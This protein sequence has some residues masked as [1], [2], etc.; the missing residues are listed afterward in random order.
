VTPKKRSFANISVGTP[1]VKEAVKAKKL[2]TTF[3]ISDHRDFYQFTI[4]LAYHYLELRCLW[5]KVKIVKKR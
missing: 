5:D 2:M 3:D 1:D 4:S